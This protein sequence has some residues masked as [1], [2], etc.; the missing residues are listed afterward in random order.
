MLLVTVKASDKA[1][2]RLDGG[3]IETMAYQRSW[4]NFFQAPHL[5]S[6]SVDRI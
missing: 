1:A 2:Y 5:S 3:E 4:K 6:I